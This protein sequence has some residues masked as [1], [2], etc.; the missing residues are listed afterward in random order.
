MYENQ[1]DQAAGR[2]IVDDTRPTKQ[3]ADR[4]PVLPVIRM[5]AVTT[6]YYANFTM[7][8]S[9]G[10]GDKVCVRA[11]NTPTRIELCSFDLEE[12]LPVLVWSE[13]ESPC[14]RFRRMS[15]TGVSP[16]SS[17]MGSWSPATLTCARLRCRKCATAL[18]CCRDRRASEAGRDRAAAVPQPAGQAGRVLANGGFAQR[19]PPSVGFQ[20]I[21]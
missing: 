1:A 3:L 21:C 14:C 5:E 15:N 18:G 11:K 9:A 13:R 16:P 4:V 20:P 2:T 6:D 10:L 8:R 19:H 7:T 17:P 12:P